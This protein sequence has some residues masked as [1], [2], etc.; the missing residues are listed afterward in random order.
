MQAFSLHNDDSASVSWRALMRIAIPMMAGSAVRYF[1]DLSNFFWTAKLGLRE[2]SIASALSYFL[3]IPQS[4]VVLTTVGTASFVA[5]QRGAGDLHS[6]AKLGLLTTRFA[7]FLGVATALVALA[8]R[9]TVFAFCNIPR[10]AWGE[11]SL[12]FAL[13]LCALPVAF[14][15]NTVSSALVG[16]DDPTGSFTVNVIG[17]TVAFI[18]TPVMIFPM[19]MGLSGAAVAPM[20]G[21]SCGTLY[22]LL[23]G[24]R[25]IGAEAWD[26]RLLLRP[27]RF[28]RVR[29][30]FPVFK[31]GVPLMV[32]ALYYGAI[33]FAMISLGSRFGEIYVAGFATDEKVAFA[34]NL[35]AEGLARAS[36]VLVGFHLGRQDS[37]AAKLAFG[38]ALVLTL[39]VALLGVVCVNL[40]AHQIVGLFSNKEEYVRVASVILRISS[41]GIIFLGLREVTDAC[42]GGVGNTIPSLVVGLV[43]ALA[44]LPLAYFL[45]YNLHLGGYGISWSFTLTLVAQGVILP[46]WFL[47]SFNA[48]ARRPV[49]MP[50]SQG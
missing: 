42:F 11:A 47:A 33:S 5:R 14:T 50:S 1:A 44:R 17:M 15:E 49:A 6:A 39:G 48:Y 12:Y 19:H 23:R 41:I 20:V 10:A 27:L 4:L 25:F 29:F 21:Y 34:L 9:D 3:W 40:F 13:Q 7:L 2:L 36:V 38:K 35:P 30:F 31:V 45:A 37:A 18:L 8:C 26:L 22:G 16:L 28:A 46:I 43:S 24:R 32:D